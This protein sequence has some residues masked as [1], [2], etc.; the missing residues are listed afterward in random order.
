MK[1]REFGAV[2]NIITPN[3]KQTNKGSANVDAFRKQ[4]IVN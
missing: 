3:P 1:E 2:F 4:E